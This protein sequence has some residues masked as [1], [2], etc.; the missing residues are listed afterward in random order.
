[1]YRSSLDKFYL[2]IVCCE[3]IYG[4]YCVQKGNNDHFHP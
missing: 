3:D 2:N 4:R 1:M